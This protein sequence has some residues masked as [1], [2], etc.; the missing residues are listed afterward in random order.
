MIQTSAYLVAKQFIGMHE[1]AGNE[2]NA[3]IVGF[4]QLID[5]DYKHDEIAWCSV[6]VHAIAFMLNMPRHK[7][8]N[9]RGWLKIG[10]PITLDQAMINSDVVILNRGIGPQP[11]PDVINAPGHVGFFAGLSVDRKYVS[12]LA[13]NQG[14]KVCITQFPVERILGIVRLS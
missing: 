4:G 10:I 11:G 7:G 2:D 12:L 9:A 8:L 6:F 3:L 13:G 5:P 1:I 14:D